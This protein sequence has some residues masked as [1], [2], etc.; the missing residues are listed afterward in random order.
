[1]ADVIAEYMS[2]SVEAVTRGVKDQDG[3]QSANH[4]RSRRRAVQGK[5]KSRGVREMISRSAWRFP[6]GDPPARGDHARNCRD[7]TNCAAHI[8]LMRK[9][10]R[11]GIECAENRDAGAQHVDR[12]RRFWHES[13]NGGDGVPQPIVRRKLFANLLVLCGRWKLAVEK[14]PDD[15]LKTGA[16]RQFVNVIAAIEKPALRVNG[17]D[18]RLTGNHAVQ[19][20]AIGRF[21]LGR[22]RSASAEL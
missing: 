9:I 14:Q 10:V 17:T 6:L 18:P 11:L 4:L 21:V 2:D 13:K 22:H 3:V 8:R 7:D 1:M 16:C 19:T 5:Q 12:L 20:R 15:V